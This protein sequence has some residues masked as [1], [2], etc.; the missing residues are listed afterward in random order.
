MECPKCE[1][2]K[3]VLTRDVEVARL[4]KISKEG[5]IN[6]RPYY[7]SEFETERDYLSCDNIEHC[8]E[9]FDYQEEIDEKGYEHIIEV[10]ERE[11]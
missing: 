1:K 11:E 4:Y 2:G 6:K 10:W 9:D 5:K 7:D 3:L 8:G